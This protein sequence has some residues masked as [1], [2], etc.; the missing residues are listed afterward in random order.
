M[1]VIFNLR[2]ALHFREYLAFSTMSIFQCDF[3]HSGGE[4][5]WL[6]LLDERTNDYD[7]CD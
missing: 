2:K 6:S 5:C 3:D 1:Y 7:K 4:E